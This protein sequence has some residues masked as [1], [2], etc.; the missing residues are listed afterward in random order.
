M[1]DLSTAEE[2][3]LA[4]PAYQADR[5]NQNSEVVTSRGP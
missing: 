4:Q 5:F 1:S 3:N 2:S